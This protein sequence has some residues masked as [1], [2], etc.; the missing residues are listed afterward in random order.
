M[1]YREAVLLEGVAKLESGYIRIK[2]R[3]QRKTGLPRENPL[4]FYPRYWSH[5]VYALGGC[6]ITWARLRLILRRIWNDP[7][8]REYRD[9]AIT[10][11]RETDRLFLDATRKSEQAEIRRQHRESAEA[12]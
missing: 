11:D 12:A 8:K 4:I 6:V 1:A 7:K 9:A 10:R 5:V 3:R 2:R